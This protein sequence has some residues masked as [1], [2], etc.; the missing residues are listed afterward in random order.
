MPS[1]RGASQGFVRLIAMN[2]SSSLGWVL[3]PIGI[4]RFTTHA[5]ELSAQRADRLGRPS[6]APLPAE[7]ACGEANS[8][9]LAP[10]FPRRP[11]AYRLAV[12]WEG[13]RPGVPFT[14]VADR[15]PQ[16]PSA[17]ISVLQPEQVPEF[18]RHGEGEIG[19]MDVLLGHA[20]VRER[21]AEYRMARAG[22]APTAVVSEAHPQMRMSG[23]I[24]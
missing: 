17:H 20:D 10:L 8:L 6:G 2:L 1:Q 7:Q 22:L 11:N 24:V 3:R 23:T 13:L 12:E 16:R 14:P 21:A 15:H 4:S 18:M 9:L 5:G 19:A